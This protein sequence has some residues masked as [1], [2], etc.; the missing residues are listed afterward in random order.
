MGVV[1]ISGAEHRK[2]KFNMYTFNTIFFS[3][4]HLIQIMY[5]WCFVLYLEDGNVYRKINH[6]YVF[7]KK[8]FLV[9]LEMKI[10]SMKNLIAIQLIKYIL[11]NNFIRFNNKITSRPSQYAIAKTG[12][13]SSLI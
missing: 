5:I 9:I 2:M 8:P 7:F 13:L 1:Y 4:L 11:Q 10:L 6:N 12:R 3:V